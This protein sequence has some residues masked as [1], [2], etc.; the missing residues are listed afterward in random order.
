MKQ[1]LQTIKQWLQNHLPTR[2]RI[3]QLY[4]SL[5]FNANLKGFATGRIYAGPLKN[6]C[7]PGLHCYSCPGAAA[8][9][10]LGALQNALSHSNKSTPYFV[11]GIL[12][13]YGLFFGRW[14]CGFLCP[15]GF[16]QDLL[17]KIRTPKLKKGRW[18]RGL[19]YLKYVILIALVGVVPLVYALWDFPLPGF[20]K[21]IC[22]SGTLGGAVLLLLHPAND[23]YFGMLGGLFTW[24][25]AVLMAIVIGCIFL[26]RMFCRFLCPLGAIYGLFNK[27]SFLGVKVDKGACT[28]CGICVNKCKMDIRH[29]GDHECISCGDCIA[30]CP[31]KAISYKGGRFFIDPTPTIPAQEQ[32]ADT[33]ISQEAPPAEEAQDAIR[34]RNRVIRIV[35]FCLATVLLAGALFYYNCVDRIP[36]EYGTKVGDVCPVIDLPLIGAD[37]GF[38][39]DGMI[40]AEDTRGKVTFFNF[41]Y[42]TCVACLQEMPHFSQFASDYRE[43]ATVI[44]VHTYTE[45][46]ANWCEDTWPEFMQNLYGESEI[47][48]AYDQNNDFCSLFDSDAYPVTVVLD[49]DGVILG[50][51]IGIVSYETLEAY[52]IGEREN[53]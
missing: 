21:Y 26:Y 35:S 1:K 41:W 37:T 18:S 39:S 49:A 44:A 20:C 14:I 15:F 46:S 16:L 11:L 50:I 2:R 29:V 8:S 12:L 19:S 7:Y 17:Y 13:L 53:T 10:P 43:E 38:T 24:K 47:L 33:S 3:I 32:V 36:I 34:G 40:S 22:P 30:D 9:C 45:D 42:T 27:I 4:A 5:L 31:T 48:Y 6:M 28:D 51:H 52:V 23:K 25:F